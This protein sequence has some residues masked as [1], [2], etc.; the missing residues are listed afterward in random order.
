MDLCSVYHEIDSLRERVAVRFAVC[1][2][3]GRK[4]SW[5]IVATRTHDFSPF[6]L[7]C[8]MQGRPAALRPIFIAL[9]VLG[10]LPL[11]LGCRD[12]PNAWIKLEPAICDFGHVSPGSTVTKE[13]KIENTGSRAIYLS[14]IKGSCGCLVG[15][16]A[17]IAIAPG[18]NHQV[19]LSLSYE[20]IYVSPNASSESKYHNEFLLVFDD[21]SA[22]HSFSVRVPIV[23]S[24]L[25]WIRHEPSELLLQEFVSAGGHQAHLSIY[26][27]A[28]SP[29]DFQRLKVDY[30]PDLVVQQINKDTDSISLGIDV[31]RKRLPKSFSQLVLSYELPGGT[32]VEQIPVQW[33]K[34]VLQCIPGEYTAFV[35]RRQLT[36]AAIKSSTRKLLKLESNNGEN[37]KIIGIKALDRGNSSVFAWEICEEEFSGEFNVWVK[38]FPASSAVYDTLLV[39]YR[40]QSGGNGFLTIGASVKM[41]VLP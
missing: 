7:D 8:K 31:A 34:R 5:L 15:R 13:V 20:G 1:G 4:L 26:R 29:G 11:V 38:S 14:T 39:D 10:L 28:L 17:G 21:Q 12:D 16:G 32:R 40:T 19:R 33:D 30:S 22:G 36:T 27:E 23:A 35:A 6:S 41:T 18:N 37:I 25:P 9:P 24:P 3:C 2:L